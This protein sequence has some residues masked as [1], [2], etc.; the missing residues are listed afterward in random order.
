MPNYNLVVTSKFQPLSYERYLQPYKEY[1]EAYNR[2][3]QAYET[4]SED[5][6]KWG[7]QLDTSSEAYSMWNEF[8]KELDTAATRLQ[9]EGL[10]AG[11]RKVFSNI[12]KLYG[13]NI[14]A[15]EEADK[16][17]FAAQ[18][19]RDQVKAKDSSVEYKNELSID[20]FLH[21]KTAS[22][23]S[24]SGATL[25]AETADIAAKLGQSMYSNPEFSK[26]MGGSYWQIAQAN[27]YSPTILG[28]IRSDEWKNL[29]HG[30]NATEEQNKL[31]KD[32]QQV[33]ELYQSQTNRTKG[34]SQD[35]QNRLNE[36]IFQGMYAGLEKPKY[37]YQRN[38]DYM[39]AAE[40]ANNAL[41]WANLNQRKKEFEEEMKFKQDALGRKN[42]GNTGGNSGKQRT[43]RI[44]S[45]IIITTH[46][47]GGE[48]KAK[49][50]EVMGQN[51][52]VKLVDGAWDINSRY[53]E[54]PK[55]KTYA[56][57]NKFEKVQV[58]KIIKKDPPTNYLYWV[59]RLKGSRT[60]AVSI[61]PKDDVIT[62]PPINY[63]SK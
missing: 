48:D 1:R 53:A 62:S 30:E 9:K 25:R 18:T 3:Q 22:N 29:P 20:D 14:K 59:G 36:Q 58:E 10:V 51:E 16:K 23:E 32:I 50:K 17:R 60:H 42:G 52:D 55:I 49:N 15:I 24:L 12:R 38:L 37:D 40:K 54:P 45:P 21:G 41:G 11:N 63:N 57:L 35:A 31:Y 34:Y 7:E 8:Q 27:G 44:K 56:E 61:E 46:Y 43:S 28:Y 5:S 19:L 13:K 26:V 47:G 4:L 33:S 39:T 6:S 2:Q